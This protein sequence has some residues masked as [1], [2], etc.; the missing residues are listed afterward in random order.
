MRLFAAAALTGLA[1]VSLA[2]CGQPTPSANGASAPGAA[3]AA[4]PAAPGPLTAAQVPHRRAGLWRQVTAMD[5]PATG[6]GMQFCV[7]D[8]S[9]AQMSAFAAQHMPGGH[10]DPPQLVRNLDGSINISE[11]CDMG[12]N[13]KAVT[14]GVITGDFNTSYS[15][16]LDTQMSGSPIA[17][18]NGDH[19]MTVTGT[20]TGPC[21]PGQHGGDMIMPDGTTRN[22]LAD[23]A[24]SNATGN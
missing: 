1:L 15:E 5:G 21:A 7:D 9:E 23:L 11:S 20:W 6:P 24:T 17:Q 10:C 4:P 12:A 14:T 3:P 8:N 18:M 16:S 2:A 22:M 13:G 19:K